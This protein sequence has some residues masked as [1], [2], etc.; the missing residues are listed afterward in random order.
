MEDYNSFGV[1]SAYQARQA[2][3]LAINVIAI[4]LLVMAEAMEYQRP[5]RSGE[6]VER[7]YQRVRAVVER[8]PADRPS[9]PDIAAIAEL[10]RAGAFT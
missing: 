1:T 10:I 5:L 6:G 4:E 3:D 9:S 2:V 8:L 7:T